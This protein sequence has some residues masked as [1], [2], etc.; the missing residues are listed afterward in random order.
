[1]VPPVHP[2]AEPLRGARD[3]RR[4][5][6]DEVAALARERLEAVLL[7]LRLRAEPEAALDP[8]LDPEALAVEAVLVALVEAAERLVALE[9]VLERATPRR[10]DGER[11][12]RG[13]RPVD[14]APGLLAPVLLPQA[15]ED[16]FALPP[17]EHLELEGGVI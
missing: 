14:E 8:D 12:V 16:A 11:L 13:D 3:L 9:D 6:D 2:L 7:D 1:V 5:P 15:L 10:V 17:V 4:R